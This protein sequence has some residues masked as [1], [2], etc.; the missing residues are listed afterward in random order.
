MTRTRVLIAGLGDSG[1]LTAMHLAGRRDLE[2]VGVSVKPGL[3]SG[4]EL[5]TRLARPDDW[6][7]DYRIGFD[8]YRRLDRVRRIHGELTGLDL[9][10]REVTVRTYADEVV[11]E[12]WDVLVVATGVTNGFWRRPDLQGEDEV[13]AE[14]AATHARL[15]GSDSI[16]VVGGGAAAVSSAFQL[17]LTWP[18]KEVALAFPGERALPRHHPRAWHHV[19]ARLRAAGVVL[20]PGRRAVLP[21]GFRADRI[22]AG[23]VDWSGGQEPHAADAVVWAIGRVRPNTGWLPAELLDD[24]GFVRTDSTLQAPEHPEVFAIGDV[25]AT[26]P[27]RSSARGRA[28]RLLAR[29]IGAHLDD[30]PMREFTPPRNR[31]GSVL[32]V[33]PDGLRVF[34]PSGRPFRFP[35][36]SVERVLQP[37]IVRRGIYGGVRHLRHLL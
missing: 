3:V 6:A 27:L 15:A 28:D 37:W 19:E 2:V 10:A 24:E 12:P 23:P 13:A 34:A 25:A 9:V 16:L 21:E 30:L 17:A 36:W 32:G 20:L 29:N 1:L 14:L 4:Q 5:G 22:T 11:A 33:E 7:R 35:A 31:W 18:E 8:R 26:D